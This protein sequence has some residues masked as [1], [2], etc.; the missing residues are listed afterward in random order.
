MYLQWSLERLTA[1]TECLDC[2]GLD[3][4]GHLDLPPKSKGP[5][6]VLK[7]LTCMDQIQQQL[8]ELFELQAF[9]PSV[10]NRAKWRGF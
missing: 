2:P 7:K 10:G 5:P 8:V 4:G 6:R 3:P 9:R 1:R